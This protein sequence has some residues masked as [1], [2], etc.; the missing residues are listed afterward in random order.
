M[1]DAGLWTDG[2]YF[3]R[4]A[5][6]ELSGSG[7]TFSLRSETP[8][9]Q[10]WNFEKTYAGTGCSNFDGRV[11]DTAEGEHIAKALSQEKGTHFPE[12]RGSDWSI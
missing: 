12:G 11:V 10:R 6:A 1:E 7:V 9:R 5:A 4:Q 8:C 2:R 3:V